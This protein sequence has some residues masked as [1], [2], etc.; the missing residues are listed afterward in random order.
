MI[1]IIFCC[2]YEGYCEKSKN[3]VNVNIHHAKTIFGC[4]AKMKIDSRQIGKYQ[5]VEFIVCHTHVTSSPNKSHLH[6]SHR[7]L[8]PTQS[9]EIDL[10]DSYGIAPKASCDMMARGVGGRENLGFIPW[11]RRNYLRTRRTTQMRREILVVFLNIFNVC[12]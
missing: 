9:A 12:N 11:D 8:T 6:R 4:L 5:V 10:A 1:N 3:D 2:S 7:K